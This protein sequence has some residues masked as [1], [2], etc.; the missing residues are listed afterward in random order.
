MS[1]LLQ[2]T[3]LTVSFPHSGATGPVVRNVS[4]RLETGRALAIVGES[5][6]GKSV[7]AR[8]L[9]GLTGAESVVEAD[10]LEI[11]GTDVSTNSERDWRALRGKDI[12][13]VLQD[14]LVSLDPLRTV[15]QEIEEALVVHGVRGKAERQARVIESLA[16]AGVPNPQLRSRQRSGELSGGLRQRALI[17]QALALNPRV[18]I[19]DEPTTAL[20]ATVQS[21]IIALLH[22]LK[23]RDHGL[24][25]ISHDLAVVSSIADDVLVLRDGEVVEYSSADEVL[26]NPRHPYTR[27]LLDSVPVTAAK[28]RRLSAASTADA[29]AAVEALSAREDPAAASLATP[30]H[31]SLAHGPQVHDSLAHGSL[32]HGSAAHGPQA[33]TPAA[34]GPHTHTSAPHGSQA[35]TPA[36]HDDA[37]VAPALEAIGLV[38]SYRG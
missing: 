33:H 11:L 18:L 7:I 5:G 8:T 9:V 3:N 10:R 15:G 32:E 35:H 38:K 6:S 34:H 22:D 25:I 12:G 23:S 24:I 20:D 16:A 2:V 1:T 21:Q 13:F 29:G 26:R 37:P 30:V 27:R 36:A 31:G 19:A 14:A 4:F 28:G 17:A